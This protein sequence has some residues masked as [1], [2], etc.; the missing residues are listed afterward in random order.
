MRDNVVKE[1][2]NRLLYILIVNN[3]SR[4]VYRLTASCLNQGD[5]ILMES[6]QNHPNNQKKIFQVFDKVANTKVKAPSLVRILCSTL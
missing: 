6:P 3:T 5:S 2:I 1:R 4:N